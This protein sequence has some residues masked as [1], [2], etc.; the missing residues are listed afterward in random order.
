MKPMI[1]HP[2]ERD[3]K[4]NQYLDKANHAPYEIIIAL[5]LGGF[6]LFTLVVLLGNF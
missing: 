2:E 5:L 6:C 4:V 1:W 3:Q